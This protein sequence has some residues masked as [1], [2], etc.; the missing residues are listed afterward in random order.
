MKVTA[1]SGGVGGARMLRGLDALEGVDLT[2]IVNVGDDEVIYG[3]HVSPDID[4]VIYTLAGTEGPQGWGI[5]EDAHNVMTS[6]D[7]FPIDTWFRMGDADIA[8]NLFRTTRL[9]QGWTLSQVTTA[10]AAVFGLKAT[11]V[12]ATDDPL[13]TEVSVPEDGWIAFQTYFV[14]RRHQAEIDDL[15]FSGAWAA[16]PAPGVIES[17][18]AADVVVIGPSNPPLSIWPILAVAEVADALIAADRVVAISPLFGGRPL[19]GPADRVMRGVGLPPGTEGI[20]AAYEGLLDELIVDISDAAD[21]DRIDT[22][23]NVRAFDTRI[24]DLE[25]ALALAEELVTS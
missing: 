22:D 12:P 11:I 9:G 15:R 3:L 20:L 8:T 7:K 16:T 6:L 24:G 1:L 14:D 18:Q 19:K 23:V 5:A 2:A 13:R 25:A 10:Q 21:I 4:T 17:I